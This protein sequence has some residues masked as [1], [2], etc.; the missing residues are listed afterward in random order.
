MRACDL[1]TITGENGEATAIL[2][3]LVSNLRREVPE[4]YKTQ[5]AYRF[6]FLALGFCLVDIYQY[7]G[8]VDVPKECFGM[9]ASAANSDVSKKL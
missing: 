9:P 2:K 8:A 1:Y 6:K 4:F 7:G 3:L 5:D